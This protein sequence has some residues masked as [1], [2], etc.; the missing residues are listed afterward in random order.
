M[1]TSRAL[2]TISPSKCE[3]RKETINLALG[4]DEVLVRTLWSGV[5][6]G[7]ESIVVRGGV[8]ESEHQRMRGPNQ[9]GDFSFPVKYGYSSVGI[10]E[11]IGSQVKNLRLGVKVFC[12]YPHQD[13]YLVPASQV[14]ELPDQTSTAEER[15][16]LTPNMETALNVIWDAGVSAGDKICVVGGG[17]VGLLIAFLCVRTPGCQ[18]VLK[19]P[20]PRTEQCKALGIHIFNN[21]NEFDIV[22]HASG[23]PAGLADCLSLA[24]DEAII[25]EAS[26]HANQLCLLPLGQDFHVRRLTIKSSQVGSLPPHKRPRWTYRRRLALA[27]SLCCSQDNFALNSLLE[28]PPLEF[29]HPEFVQTY[30]SLFPGRQQEKPSTE[31]ATGL[32]FRIKYPPLKS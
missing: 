5:S 1:R 21:Q 18:V 25:V 9:G 22:I 14:I 28:H 26:W 2:W 29:D 32:C 6:R 15:A 19:D 17:V 24:S 13:L 12:L 30:L 4:S 11:A 16:V 3:I 8:P 31:K 10:I 7:T 20:Q 27:L 23:N